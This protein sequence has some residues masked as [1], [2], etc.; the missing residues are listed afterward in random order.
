MP[1]INMYMENSSTC[2]SIYVHFGNDLLNFTQK[3]TVYQGVRFVNM[4]QTISSNNP[5]VT[6]DTV[7]FVLYTKRILIQDENSSTVALIDTTANVAG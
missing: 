1:L 3:T 7:N 5:A 4:T 6:F 2:A